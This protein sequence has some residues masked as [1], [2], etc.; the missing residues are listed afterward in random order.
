MIIDQGDKL[1]R[2]RHPENDQM[3]PTAATERTTM[4]ET[5]DRRP[6]IQ[7]LCIKT[8]LVGA[9][10][11]QDA[12]PSFH[13]MKKTPQTTKLIKTEHHKDPMIYTTQP[14]RKAWLDSRHESHP[15]ANSRIQGRSGLNLFTTVLRLYHLCCKLHV[16]P[17][18][19]EPSTPG[20]YAMWPSRCS[21]IEAD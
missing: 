9:T 18:S 21:Q 14:H 20:S 17:I 5:N 19:A 8:L 1:E 4:V 11:T 7:P 10:T 12:I 13:Y 3:R 15:L 2:R 16:S 6:I